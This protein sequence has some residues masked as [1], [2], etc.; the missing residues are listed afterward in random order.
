MR[1]QIRHEGSSIAAALLAELTT[2]DNMLRKN[3]IEKFYQ[4]TLDYW[5]E[6]GEVQDRETIRDIL[7]NEPQSALPVYY[8]MVSKLGLLPRPLAADIVEY[9]ALAVSINRTIVRFIANRELPPEAVKALAYS[10]EQQWKTI[11]QL[12]TKL[13]GELTAFADRN[14]TWRSLFSV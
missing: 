1:W 4:D 13:I 6:T 10:I 3:N 2:V 12:R 5:K 11:N 7:D 9:H 14:W 8:S